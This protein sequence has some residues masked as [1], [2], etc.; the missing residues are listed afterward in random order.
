MK[1][2]TLWQPWASAIALGL[3]KIETRGWPTK[4]RGPLAIHAATRQHREDRACFE[5][6]LAAAHHVERDVWA[7]YCDSNYEL[8]PFGEVVATC[9]LTDC[10]WVESLDVGGAERRWGDYSAG[11]WGW[12]LEEVERL[13]V[14][15]PAVGRQGLWDWTQ[16]VEAIEAQA[17]QQ[18]LLL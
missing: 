12:V 14:P 1:A 16:A 9:R 7:G 8:L 5:A 2:L 11:R 4:Y 13:M 15:V 18:F 10:L 3:K 6:I 17:P